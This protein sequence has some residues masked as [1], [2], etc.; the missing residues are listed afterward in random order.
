MR[1]LL[2]VSCKLTMRLMRGSELTYAFNNTRHY[3]LYHKGAISP[4]IL[5]GAKDLTNVHTGLLVRFFAPLRMT[6]LFMRW[7]TVTCISLFQL[8]L[9]SSCRP[10]MYNQ[11][12]AKPESATEF[13]ND[14]TT[15]R[16]L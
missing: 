10:D 3:R 7:L 2:R 15:A 11:P 4:V 1:L 6:P 16:R 5:S 13:F 12:K 14:G 8:T 9:F